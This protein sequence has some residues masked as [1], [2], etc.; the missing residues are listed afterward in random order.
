M[1]GRGQDPE[2]PP[3][4]H[5]PVLLEE[6]VSALAPRDGGVYVDGTFGAGGYTQAVLDAADCT[7]IAI[8]RDPD[9]I[10][11]GAA[12]QARYGARLILVAGCFGDLAARLAEPLASLGRNCIDGLTLDLGV[13]S[14]QLD[15][16]ARGFSFMRDGPLDM[17]MSKAGPS[18]ADIVNAA[19]E[20]ELAR[21][22][23]VYGEEKRAR[24]V[25]R[26]IVA[27]RDVAPIT[28]TAQLVSILEDVLGTAY[29]ARRRHPNKGGAKPAHP[30]TRTFQAL[31]IFVND[32]LGE[33]TRAL[34]AAETRLAPAGR[35]AIVTFHSLEDRMVKR[36]L[37][38]RT[39]RVGRPS[40]HMPDIN[41]PDASFVELDRRSSAPRATEVA[42][43]PR[44]RSARL[45][46]AQRTQAAAF[47]D[48]GHALV[49]DGLPQLA[50]FALAAPSP[51][52]TEARA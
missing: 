46:A 42:A 35:L 23:A 50:K 32:E 49:R 5:L 2:M 3:R 13:S 33:L 26:A 47:D 36:F 48:A 7:V 10:A 37:S 20:A 30:A 1:T 21:I 4:P 19:A 17:R 24:A 12:L 9:A 22:I 8:D 40:R 14:M 6:V 38:L 28:E 31:R 45:R 52:A 43:N 29:Q 15:Q 41:M 34:M 51:S 25:A 16:G 27:A 39:G 44:A 11:N 18:A